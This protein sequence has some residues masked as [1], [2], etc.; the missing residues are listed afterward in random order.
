MANLLASLLGS[1]QSLDA[2]S[3]VLQVTQNNVAN[4]ST[5]GWARQSLPLVA[6]QSDLL[7]GSPGGVTV[8]QMQSARN[9]YAEQA[10]RRQ[11]TGLGKQ[12]QAVS[13]LTS[14]Q[15]IFNISGQTGISY[16]LNQFFQA[17][18]AWA[19]SPSDQAAR[20]LVIDRATDVGHDFQSAAV[21][22]QSLAHDTDVTLK[23]TVGQINQITSQVLSYNRRILQSG[24][25]T[26]DSGI[27]AQIHAALENLSQFV[28]ISAT[29]EPDGTTT[30]LLNGTTPLLIADHQYDLRVV[31]TAGASNV[32]STAQL[33]AAD[34][35]DLTA[36]TTNGQLGELLDMR[37]SVIPYYSGDSTQPGELNRLAKAFADRVNQ[38]FTSGNI[39]DGP[40]AVS[41]VPLFTYD[42]A[43]PTDV[44]R[45]LAV[46]PTVTAGQLS[47]IAPGPPYVSN[48]V[49]LALSNLA[50][51]TD[52]TDQIDGFSY[53]EF[54]GNLASSA[55]SKLQ[56]AQQNEQVQQSL[57]S[58]AEDQRKQLSGVSLD[59]EA[60]VLVE[61]QRAYQANSRLI[62]VLDQLTEE[63]VNIIH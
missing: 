35:T 26:H 12:Q 39:S 53:T 11:N 61:F 21:Q 32:P 60:M 54:Y 33:L 46:D 57:L 49:P 15:S 51:P 10:V 47:A 42:E 29:Q 16:S 25:G 37:N 58:Q 34:G 1:A 38:L 23:S 27:D 8:G 7:A 43:N 6:L 24:S 44:A 41:G 14:L 13:S 9:E 48:G 19:Q 56:T 22:L 2:Y 40:P 59:E 63:I 55:G 17:S 52:A 18:S 36:N 30:V 20:Q 3:K 5:P 45:T 28:D 31:S 50:T 4:A 62:S